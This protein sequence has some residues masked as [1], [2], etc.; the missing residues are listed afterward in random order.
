M[1]DWTIVEWIVAVAAV[2][3]LVGGVIAYFYIPTFRLWVR[4]KGK[5]A[6]MS[7]IKTYVVEQARSI[8]EKEYKAIAKKVLS[9]E[10]A[11]VEAV[12]AELYR[13]GD[14]LKAKTKERFAG[15]LPALGEQADGI[16][17]DLIRY[18]AD[19]TSPF[20]GK[21]TAAVLLET[22][23]SDML[24]N[25]GIEYVRREVVRGSI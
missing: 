9:G 14:I 3:A 12:K 1:P 20:P 18:A 10:L 2:L 22:Q 16:L 13:L 5:D 17:D 23:V 8:A 25:K 6:A 7:I 4:T 21:E 15:D 24:V 19:T 11:S